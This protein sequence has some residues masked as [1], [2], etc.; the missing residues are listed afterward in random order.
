MTVALPKRMAKRGTVVLRDDFGGSSLNTGEWEHEVSMYG[1]YVSSCFGINV[2]VNNVQELAST[3]P[4][5][6]FINRGGKNN[7]CFPNGGQT[8]TKNFTK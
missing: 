5:S 6:H 7:S 3:K 4:R 1:G 2:K 8:V